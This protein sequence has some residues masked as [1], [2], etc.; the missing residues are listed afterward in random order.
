MF[1]TL[2]IPV[3]L[4]HTDQMDKA[5]ATSA[6]HIFASHA[7]SIP[8]RNISD[9]DPLITRNPRA[10]K[11]GPRRALLHTLKAVSDQAFTSTTTRPLT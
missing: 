2:M 3:D 1:T 10:T 11:K 7:A 5:V 4:V 6:K 8:Q 9:H